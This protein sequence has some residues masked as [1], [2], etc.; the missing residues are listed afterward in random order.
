MRPCSITSPAESGNPTHAL[1]EEYSIYGA[2]RGA[3]SPV[4]GAAA[5]WQ[6]YPRTPQGGWGDRGGQRSGRGRVEADALFAGD[7][8]DPTSTDGLKRCVKPWA[9]RYLGQQRR[10]IRGKITEATDA[11]LQQS[12]ALNVEARSVSAEPRSQ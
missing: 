10:I 4:T 12:F 11:D 2:A 7:L 3:E 9:D 1:N 5:Y 8:T 6:S